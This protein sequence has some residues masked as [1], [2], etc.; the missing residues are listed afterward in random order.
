MVRKLCLVGMLVV[1]GRGSVAQLFLAV[2]I[3]FVTFSLQIT[4]QPYKHWEDNLFKAA[5]EVHIF[6][7][8]SVALVLKCL[9]YGE[10]AADEVLPIGFYDTVLIGS[11]IVGI[12]AGFVGTI[13]AK[14]RMMEQVLQEPA[15]AGPDGDDSA[16]AKRRAIQLLHLGLTTNEDMRLLTAYFAK[17]DAMVN[18][19][20][21]VFISYRVASDRQLARR[22]YDTLSEISIGETGQR[23]RVYLDQTRLEDGQRWDSGFMQGLANSWV[24]V[25]I[26][27]VGSVGPMV[28]L[29]Q[30]EDWTDNVLLEWAAALEL[31]QRGRLKAVLPLLVGQT[32]FFVDAQAFGGVQALPTRVSVATMEKVA[33]HL[34]QTTG[35]GSIGGLEELLRQVAGTPEATVQGVVASMLKFQGVKL[36]Q[37]GAASAHSHGHM[38][39]AMDDLTICTSRIQATVASCLKRVGVVEAT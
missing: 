33:E 17:L 28:Q 27:S 7:L 32:D 25:P 6:L 4:L 19:M 3:S 2:V 29:G 18:K 14:R 30:N 9:R 16:T 11:F 13:C 12:P 20:T 22:L 36:S 26:V 38:S 10:G 21:H 35:E 1:A 5:V 24:F 15:A 39:V 37:A 23:I 34:A 8:V 31:H